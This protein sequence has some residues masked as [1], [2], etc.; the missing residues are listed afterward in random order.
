MISLDEITDEITPPS[1]DHLL[2]WIVIMA[3]SFWLGLWIYA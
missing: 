2:I 1:L 3:A